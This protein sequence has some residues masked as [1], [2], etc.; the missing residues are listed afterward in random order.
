MADTAPRTMLRTQGRK[1]FAAF[2]IRRPVPATRWWRPPWSCPW[3]PCSWSPSAAGTQW[4][5]RRRP[6]A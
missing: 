4:S 6:W 1:A 5:H 3:R 2:G